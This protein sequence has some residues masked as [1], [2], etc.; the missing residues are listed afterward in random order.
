M[1]L[2]LRRAQV[3]I[4]PPE[5]VLHHRPLEGTLPTQGGSIAVLVCIFIHVERDNVPAGNAQA[6][7]H[8]DRCIVLRHR[9]HGENGNQ[10][11]SCFQ[12]FSNAADD[13]QSKSKIELRRGVDHPDMTGFGPTRRPR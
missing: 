9:P 4:Q 7:D 3:R 8:F 6:I 13:V 10:P 2:A 5:K 11:L 12:G 1:N